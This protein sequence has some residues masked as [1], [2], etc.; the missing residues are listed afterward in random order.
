MQEKQELIARI[1]FASGVAGTVEPTSWAGFMHII[2]V[3]QKGSG[4]RSGNTVL[5]PFVEAT[6]LALVNT[7]CSVAVT[8]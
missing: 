1:A 5:G 7:V 2:H 4:M 3:S 8:C 6:F